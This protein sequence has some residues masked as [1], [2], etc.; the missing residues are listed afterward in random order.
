MYI[1][2]TIDYI[3][4]KRELRDARCCLTLSRITLRYNKLLFLFCRFRD[5]KVSNLL[6]TDKG[7]VKIGKFDL[8]RRLTD[9]LLSIVDIRDQIFL[10]GFWAPYALNY[11]P[12]QYYALN[13][14]QINFAY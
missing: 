11:I 14:S 8:G 13:K 1:T 3:A 5:L 2:N 7:C 10:I 6:M 4:K 12:L 9:I